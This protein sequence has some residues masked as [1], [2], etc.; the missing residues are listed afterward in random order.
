MLTAPQNYRLERFS[1]SRKLN[2]EE[3]LGQTHTY[4]LFSYLN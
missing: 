1:I 3:L 2:R 4:I